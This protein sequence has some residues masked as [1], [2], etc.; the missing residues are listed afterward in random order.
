[1]SDT[2]QEQQLDPVVIENTRLRIANGQLKDQL[3]AMRDRTAC[4]AIMDR[5]QR[6]LNRFAADT[7]LLL[8]LLQRN[9]VAATQP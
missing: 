3:S 2:V 9:D 7:Q 4:T 1:M 6:Q 8:D 5:M